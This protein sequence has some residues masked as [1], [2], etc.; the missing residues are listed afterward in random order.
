MTDVTDTPTA[1]DGPDY[2]FGDDNAIAHEIASFDPLTDTAGPFDL[3]RMA[4]SRSGPTPSLDALTPAMQEP[5]LAQLGNLTGDRR[6][7][8][9]AEL[10]HAAL[11]QNSLDLRIMAGPGRDADEFQKTTL[12][13]ANRLRLIEQ[14]ETKLQAELQVVDGYRT[15]YH[16][17]TGEPTAVPIMSLSGGNRVGAQNRLAALAQQR[18]L[19]Q[20]SEGSRELQ[21]ALAEA[22]SHRKGIMQ[23]LADDAEAKRRAADLVREE[24]INAR[25]EAHAKSLRNT[26]G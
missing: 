24:K 23:Q 22:V 16:P 8:R 25:A 7:A 13:L 15:T 4:M 26:L 11:L 12:D 9:E 1:Y 18:A 6:A 3:S 17:E 5:I 20:G 10:V 2:G 19:I 14:E 21:A